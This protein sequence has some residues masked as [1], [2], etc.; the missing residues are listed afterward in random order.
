MFLKDDRRKHFFSI[1]VEAF[2]FQLASKPRNASLSTKYTVCLHREQTSVYFYLR[3]GMNKHI[4]RH[5]HT[6]TCT[7]QGG[8][9]KSGRL[10]W[11]CLWPETC[12][13]G[14]QS[15]FPAALKVPT[16]SQLLHH[17]LHLRPRSF[18]NTEILQTATWGANAP[19]ISIFTFAS[20]L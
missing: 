11:K 13:R 7:Q 16:D 6:Q 10:S 4:H 18:S 1:L 8:A 19:S 20:R 3:S 5:T 17:T 2:R 15:K 9:D 12:I 14:I